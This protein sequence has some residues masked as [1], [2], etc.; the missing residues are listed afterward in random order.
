MVPGTNLLNINSFADRTLRFPAPGK[1]LCQR[2][3]QLP[4]VAITLSLCPAEWNLLTWQARWQLKTPTV[5]HLTSTTMKQIKGMILITNWIPQCLQQCRMEICYRTTFLKLPSQK[6]KKAA[7]L[8]KTPLQCGQYRE[9][10]EFLNAK[11][12]NWTSMLNIYSH[13]TLQT[14]PDWS[15]W[16]FFSQ[17]MTQTW[18]SWALKARILLKTPWRN[19]VA[20]TEPDRHKSKDNIKLKTCLFSEVRVEEWLNVVYYLFGRNGPLSCV[21][22]NV[23][24]LLVSCPLVHIDNI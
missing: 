21:I 2:W 4:L 7:S 22:W 6:S 20:K 12:R 19:I 18:N 17:A 24:E 15:F 8:H 14:T 3:K 13:A 1:Q 11:D 10:S 23:K 16:S 5:H 9:G